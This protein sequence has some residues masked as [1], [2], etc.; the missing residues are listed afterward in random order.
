MLVRLTYPHQQD[1]QS[2][3][4][5]CALELI[6]GDIKEDAAVFAI[7]STHPLCN[8]PSSVDLFHRRGSSA[9]LQRCYDRMSSHGCAPARM[10]AQRLYPHCASKLHKV[11]EVCSANML[12]LNTLTQ[13]ITRVMLNLRFP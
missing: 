10:R 2:W 3:V 9:P 4:N 8:L 6:F 5:F 1:R 12:V 11:T 7:K 13:V